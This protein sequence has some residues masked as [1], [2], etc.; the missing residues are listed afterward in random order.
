MNDTNFD[1]T[2]FIE[3]AIDKL[4]ESSFPFVIIAAISPK[5]VMYYGRINEED[6]VCFNELLES[7]EIAHNLKQIFD[8]DD[9]A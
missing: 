6:G 8:C 5:R 3:D 4:A 9:N 2:D 7:G 1:S